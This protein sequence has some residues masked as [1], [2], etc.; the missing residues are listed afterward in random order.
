[1]VRKTTGFR[2]YL[3]DSAPLDLTSLTSSPIK[4]AIRLD[5]VTQ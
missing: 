1:M 2:F 3:V 5:K 4:G